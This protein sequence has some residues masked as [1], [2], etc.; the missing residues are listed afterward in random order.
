MICRGATISSLIHKIQLWRLIMLYMLRSQPKLD[1]WFEISGC[2]PKL[3]AENGK[4]KKN[5]FK[6]LPTK[7]R[8][9][10]EADQ[11]GIC[12]FRLGFVGATMNTVLLLSTEDLLSG[13]SFPSTLILAVSFLPY[14]FC[15]A[16]LPYFAERIPVSSE[17]SGVSLLY[18]WLAT[19]GA[20]SKDSVKDVGCI[21]QW[22][23]T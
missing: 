20:P 11:Y 18:G 13:T 7:G 6:W 23:R 5:S 17:H 21:L 10:G 3:C 16:I 2:K 14:V 15:A 19:D 4:G 22:A 8:L 1:K 9:Q 12:I